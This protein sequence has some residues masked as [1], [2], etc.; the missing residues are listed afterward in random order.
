MLL[1][2][3]IFSEALEM[4]TSVT[5]VAPNKPPKDSG[6]RVCYLLHGLCGNNGDFADYTTLPE[7]VNRTDV[8]FVLPEVGRSFYTDL[9]YGGSYFTYVASELPKYIA[10]V[11]HVSTRREDAAVMG[12]SMGGY[13]ALKCALLH[14]ETF[15][16][17]CA[18]AP[19][20]LFLKKALSYHRSISVE[21][22]EKQFG[23][24]LPKDVAAMFGEK[25]TYDPA[26][27]VSALIKAAADAPQKPRIYMACGL[28]D[29][30]LEQDRHFAKLVR[31]L[32]YDFTY[33]EWDG[34][35][36]WR[37]FAEM[38]E[39]GITHCFGQ[40]ADPAM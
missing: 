36:N 40:N 15:G 9:K 21:E 32:P 38:L 30:L 25:F 19:A 5:I 29:D 10:S 13:G 20:M 8:L 14:P 3:T 31:S 37:F 27:D 7:L 11:F 34:A 18:G 17:C 39:K 24:Q 35:H 12:V 22:R 28:S 16:M 33:E 26:S 2:G 6:Y 23:K 4:Q 1:R